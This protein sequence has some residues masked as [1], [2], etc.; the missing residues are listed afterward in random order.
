[1]II[2]D[3]PTKKM[4]SVTQLETRGSSEHVSS[5]NDHYRYTNK[6]MNS[7]TQLETRGSPEHVSYGTAV[8]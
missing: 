7:V 3:I 6:K 8:L 2:I 5:H 4:N 1:M